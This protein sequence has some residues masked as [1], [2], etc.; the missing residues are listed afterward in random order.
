MEF[1]QKFVRTIPKDAKSGSL[2]NSGGSGG[3][4]TDAL[5]SSDQSRIIVSRPPRQAVSLLTCSKLCMFFFVAGVVVGYTIK[6][7][8]K[9]WASKLL[10]RLK[11]D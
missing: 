4:L 3:G 8:V 5:S 7:R 2:Y 6:R 1:W 9:R 11:D 10:K